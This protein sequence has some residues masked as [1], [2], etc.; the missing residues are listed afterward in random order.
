MTN[1][2]YAYFLTDSPR[3]DLGDSPSPEPHSRPDSSKMAGSRP[4]SSRTASSLPTTRTPPSRPQSYRQLPGNRPKSGAR[5]T[6]PYAQSLHSLPKS[7]E[8]IRRLP[9]EVTMHVPEHVNP[10]GSNHFWLCMST[11]VFI[12]T[13]IIPSN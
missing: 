6:Q 11:H 12:F 9:E 4:T 3:S 13:G 2:K 1:L 7:F 5:E 10:K 8:G